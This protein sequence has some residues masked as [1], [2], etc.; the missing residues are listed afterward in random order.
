M[1][2][3][4][5]KIRSI[6]PDDYP[7]IKKMIIAFFLFPYGFYCVKKTPVDHPF[8]RKVY[9]LTSLLSAFIYFVIIIA[10]IVQ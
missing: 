10:I 1:I 5:N 2:K 8:T 9:I 3:R 4:P 7:S 6:D